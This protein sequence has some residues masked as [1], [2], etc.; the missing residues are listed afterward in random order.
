MIILRLLKSDYRVLFSKH[1]K[2]AVFHL[3]KTKIENK[4][5]NEPIWQPNSLSK[6]KK[7]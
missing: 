4:T 7:S 5:K 1:S 2:Q 6:H 3:F